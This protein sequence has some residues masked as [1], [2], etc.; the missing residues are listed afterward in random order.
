MKT[1]NKLNALLVSACMIGCMGVTT[2]AADITETTDPKTGDTEITANASL[3]TDPSYIVTIP[4]GVDLGTITKTTTSTPASQTFDISASNVSNIT[5]KQ[6]KVAVSTQNGIFK[7][8]SGD[9]NTLPFEVYNQATGGTALANN[10]VFATF[11][12]AK[13]VTGRVQVDQQDIVSTEKYSGTM[14][15][16][17]SLENVPLQ[18]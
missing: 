18:P 16:T 1:K 6:I 9:Q 8:Y 10:D 4:E 14:V 12:E 2:F 7:L 15:F 17:I 13:T 3:Q 11:T 5:G